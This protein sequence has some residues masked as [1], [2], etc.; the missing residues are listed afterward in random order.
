MARLASLVDLI[1][2][3]YAKTA[4][5]TPQGLAATGRRNGAP[6]LLNAFIA[7]IAIARSTR[8]FGSNA[9]AAAA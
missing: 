4:V 9:S 6:S 8:S 1:L 5:L 7:A 3:R 2:Y